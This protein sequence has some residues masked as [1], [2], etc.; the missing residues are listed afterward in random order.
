MRIIGPMITG[1]VN[2]TREAIVCLVVFGPGDR[3][4]PVE[5]IIDTG[6]NGYLTLPPASII[7]LGLTLAGSEPARLADGGVV[8]LEYFDATIER[9]GQRRDVLVIATDN[10]PLIGMGLLDG[11]RPTLD[12]VVVG[13]VTI[14]PLP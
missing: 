11:F 12:A 8:S 1:T 14:E 6:F 7:L 13:R 4:E 3:S 2:R 5:A 9:D 10:V